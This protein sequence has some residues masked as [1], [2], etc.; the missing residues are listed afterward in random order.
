MVNRDI[1]LDTI[2]ILKL[3]RLGTWLQNKKKN[4]FYIPFYVIVKLFYRFIEIICGFSMPFNIDLGGRICFKHGFYG[5]FISS[6]AIIGNDVIIMHQVT[7]GSNFSSNKSIVAPCIG[8]NVFIGPGAKI[9]GNVHLSDNSKV[10]ENALLINQECEQ[11]IYVS[12][13]ATK[14]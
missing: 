12:R 4:I 5:I 8:N 11:G 2:L 3:F 10:G 13:K 1:L 14:I 9:I 7:I 6:E